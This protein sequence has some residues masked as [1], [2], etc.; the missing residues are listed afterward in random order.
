MRVTQSLVVEPD[1]VPAGEVLTAW[2]PYPRVIPGQQERLLFAGSQPAAHRIAPESA[3]QRTV[4]LEQRA[5]AGQPTRFSISYELTVH[6]QVN[7]ID[8]DR[9]VP[10]DDATIARD[11]LAAHLGERAPH[12]V[13]TDAMREFSKQVVEKLN[14]RQALVDTGT[15]NRL[16]QAGYRSQNALNIFLFARFV[17][18]FIFFAVG[19]GTAILDFATKMGESIK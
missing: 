4:Q 3:P 19:A 5:K 6:G 17:L 9:V 14:L 13:Y 16:R 10:L 15:V 11:G 8:A 12:V 18:P 1:A 2:I 7:T